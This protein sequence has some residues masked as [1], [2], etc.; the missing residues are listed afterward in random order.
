MKTL[1]GLTKRWDP[2]QDFG[3]IS[4]HFE[5]LFGVAPRSVQ[6]PWVPLVDVS[7]DDKEYVI[8]AEVPE[9]KKDDLNVTVE[10][11][12]L[13]LSGE[14][15]FETEQKNKRYH[16]VERAYGSFSRSF[17]VPEDADGSKVVAT[18]KDGVLRV[19]LPKSE[20]AKPKS[21]DVKIA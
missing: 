11:G 9:V 18:F 16:R 20:A 7:E 5:N 15:K 13:V 12:V 19:S 6:K 2:F 4:K 14:R 1:T 10:D 21:I 3:D 8:T 17:T